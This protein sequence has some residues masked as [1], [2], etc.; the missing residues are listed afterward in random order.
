M[1][2]HHAPAGPKLRQGGYTAHS[3][4]IPRLG[5]GPAK[6]LAAHMLQG[7]TLQPKGFAGAELEHGWKRQSSPST[8]GS[9]TE[10][11][12]HSKW[13]VVRPRSNRAVAETLLDPSSP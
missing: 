3:V 12:C 1:T 9:R 8:N 10:E 7:P 6:D 4:P 13:G 5:E 11:G 2:D